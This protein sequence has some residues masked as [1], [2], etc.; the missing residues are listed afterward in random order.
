M[1][2]VCQMATIPLSL[3]SKFPQIYEN[4]RARSTGQLS[5]VA[6]FSQVAG[7]LARLFTTATEVGDPIVFVGFLL[8]LLL[9]LVLGA[10]MY[11]FWEKEGD[12]KILS[13]LPPR[14]KGHLEGIVV[15]PLSPLP[16][17]IQGQPPQGAKRWARK[18]D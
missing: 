13:R 4:Q 18:V 5:A 9:N 12:D 3:L 16:S 17:Q 10:Q 6:V 8:A 7:C 1:L 2:A 15:P 11:A 14:E